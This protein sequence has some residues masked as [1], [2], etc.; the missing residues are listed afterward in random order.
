MAR[1]A[2]I[3]SKQDLA[4][5]HRHV[6][7]A[8]A[9]S[10]GTV[11]GPWL[12]LLHSP[13][14]AARTM[15]L[16]SYVRFESNLDHKTVEFTALVTA[17]ELDCKHEWA[18]HVNNAQ[19]A[20]ISLETIRAVH[21]KQG[22]EKFSSEDAQIVSFVREVLHSH[23]VSEPTFQAIYARLGERGMVE[24]TGTIGY[25]AMLACTLNTFDVATA[26]PPEDLKI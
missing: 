17:R 26:V 18:A 10:R 14:L 5:E 23:R 21:Q 22:V 20:G 24:L 8:I 2:T 1:I 15:H 6:Y 25:Y 3:N 9:Q 7:D 13:E 12:A 16:G 19:K 4:A 11:G